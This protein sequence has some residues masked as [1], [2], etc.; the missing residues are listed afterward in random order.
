MIASP[1]PPSESGTPAEVAIIHLRNG[2]A[3]VEVLGEIWPD[4]RPPRDG[5]PYVVERYPFLWLVITSNVFAAVNIV[6]AVVCLIFN[7]AFRNRK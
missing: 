1:S 3:D 5:A 6:A 7:F 2:L 4:D